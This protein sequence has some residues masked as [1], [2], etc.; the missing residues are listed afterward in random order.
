MDLLEAA[1]YGQYEISN[2]ARPGRE[3]LHN[4]GYWNGD[5]YLGFGPSAFST[6][7]ARRWQNV[8]DSA[9]YI[10]RIAAG[11]RGDFLRGDHQRKNARRRDARLRPAH[12]A[13]HPRAGR[14]PWE[15]EL[16]EMRA[17]GL[18]ESARWPPPPHPAR[19][20]DGRLRGRSIRIMP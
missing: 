18:L 4:F 9:A 2:Y 8:P 3:S 15:A 13:R 1:G 11:G 14:R 20:T 12:R 7:G 19:Q 17:L 5:D 16:V 6:V 10:A